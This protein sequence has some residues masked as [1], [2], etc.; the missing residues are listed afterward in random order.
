MNKYRTVSQWLPVSYC[1]V[2][3]AACFTVT[4][5]HIKVVLS[6]IIT[7]ILLLYT[8]VD[9]SVEP[10]QPQTF[11]QQYFVVILNM[12]LQWVFRV[13]EMC[14]NNIERTRVSPSKTR[15]NRGPLLNVYP[16][17]CTLCNYDAQE[18]T[19]E[20]T[21]MLIFLAVVCINCI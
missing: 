8:A 15:R 2:G 16:A 12:V 6:S 14:C 5:F 20:I 21:R 1:R 11:T 17:L 19:I 9:N 3:T 4:I 10:F 13:R 18:M 7:H